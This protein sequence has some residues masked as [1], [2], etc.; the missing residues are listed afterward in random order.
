MRVIV[1]IGWSW[2]TSASAHVN[3]TQATYQGCRKTIVEHLVEY[4]A[5]IA[6]DEIEHM[7]SSLVTSE[8]KQKKIC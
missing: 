3:H 1:P 7:L 8:K 4:L 6:G 2:K 5:E